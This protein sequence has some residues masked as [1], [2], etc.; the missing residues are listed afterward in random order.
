VISQPVKAFMERRKMLTVAPQV[1]VSKAAKMMAS[2]K[3][4]AVLVV[5]DNRLLG[6]FTE[7]DALFRVI[8]C[9]LE[10]STTHLS[11]VMTPQPRTITPEKSFG[12]AMLLMHENGFR[13][14][15]V[16]EGGKP[17]GIVSARD[18]LDPDLEEFAAE[19]SRRK[20]FIDTR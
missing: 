16:V 3:V 13:H 19:E 7:R 4:G 11:E 20:H 10:P 5:E 14:L 6:I 1:S 2:K 8:A 12:H 9:G 15:P 17:I 18:A